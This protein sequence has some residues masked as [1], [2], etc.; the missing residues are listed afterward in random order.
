MEVNKAPEKAPLNVAVARLTEQQNAKMLQLFR[1]AYC[2]VKH[3]FTIRSFPALL[4]LQKL[5]G[6]DLRVAYQ[7]RM[8]ASVFI[9]SIA[10]V[11][12]RSVVDKLNEQEF[13]SILLD[14]STDKS[15]I[16][17]EIVYARLLDINLKPYNMFLG[18]MPVKGACAI[19]IADELG[20]F[21]DRLGVTDWKGRLSS[22]GTDGAS[23]NTG[24]QGGLGTILKKDI[25]YM[26]QIHCVAHKL[27]LS[28]L[29][30]CKTVSYVNEFQTTVKGVLKFYSRS[31]KRLR[32]LSLTNDIMD[33]NAS[34]RKFG[35]W[36]P[37]RWIMSKSRILRV[38]NENYVSTVTH[39]QHKSVCTDK[40]EASVAKGLLKALQSV[41]FVCFL[42]IMCDFTTALGK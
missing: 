19:D 5:N 17:Q 10:E 27:E 14:G 15:T 36:N 11:Q 26:L 20:D 18:L 1:T 16:E 21:L 42:A 30:A 9:A 29:D 13:F 28:V 38:M 31:S 32:E 3:N 35:K 25:P 39:L 37:I 22:L 2:I 4:S 33:T 6:L 12:V 41:R 34:L 40:G 7:N 23:V 24:S 8:A